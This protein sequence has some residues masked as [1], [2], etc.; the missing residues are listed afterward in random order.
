[1]GNLTSYTE[2]AARHF[3]RNNTLK[4]DVKLQCQSGL[5]VE[6][7]DKMSDKKRM[8]KIVHMRNIL[9]EKRQ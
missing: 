5:Y 2:K 1:M 9:T 4:K 8:G 3:V 6:Y 7:D